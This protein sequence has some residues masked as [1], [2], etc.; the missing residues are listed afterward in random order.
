MP[1]KTK[2][3][4]A[5]AV[6]CLM[7]GAGYRLLTHLPYAWNPF[8]RLDPQPLVMQGGDP[9]IRALMRTISASESNDPDPY[10]LM[11]G[12][13]HFSGDHRPNRC[14]PIHA[15]VNKGRCSTAAG[16][17]QML[18]S[19]WRTVSNRYLTPN[20]QGLILFTPNNQD[21]AVYRWLQDHSSWQRHNF[22]DMLRANQLDQVLRVLSPT[23]T[24]LGYGIADNVFT[25][26]LPN[27]YQRMLE[28][29]LHSTDSP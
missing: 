15:G 14:L 1:S 26:R 23:W 9:Y 27:V 24:S 8:Y 2:L 7:V 17:Y 25:Q 19:T 13:Q 16:R 3:I 5:L 21:L 29:E 6:V 20:A 22:A 4:V 10:H 18:F 28:Q 11:Y 12:G